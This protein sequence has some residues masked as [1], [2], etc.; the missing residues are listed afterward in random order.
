MSVCINCGSE[1]SPHKV[2]R[3]KGTAKYCDPSCHAEYWKKR[4]AG[5]NTIWNLP[6]GTVGAIN[7]LRVSVDL[8]CKGY[9]VF[10]ALSPNCPCDLVLLFDRRAFRVE[11][12]TG[13]RT[14]T[15]RLTWPV[16]DGTRFDV[17][18]VVLPESIV[19]FTDLPELIGLVEL[20]NELASAVAGGESA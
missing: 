11:V 15:G 10:R 3:T 14:S 19:Y 5:Q 2:H 1:I 6:S 12:T 8:L 13:H 16:K 4:Y 17:L 7:E 9:A 18:A 20:Q